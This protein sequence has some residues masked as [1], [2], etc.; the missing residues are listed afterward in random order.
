MRNR[1]MQIPEPILKQ[2]DELDDLVERNPEYIPV[3]EAAKFLHVNA[4]GLRCTIEKGQAPFGIAWQKN[5][6]G[7]KAFKIPTLTFYLWITQCSGFRY[8][9]QKGEE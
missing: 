6:R 2:L 8:A 1:L 9:M 4:E 7:N 3:P 5:I